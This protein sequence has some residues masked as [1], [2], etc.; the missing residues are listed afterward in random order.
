MTKEDEENFGSSMK[1]WFCNNTFVEGGVKVI[2]Y[3][4][5]TGEYRGAGHRDCNINVSVNYIISIVFYNLKNHDTHLIM[6]ELGNF[7]FEINFIPDGLEKYTS[8][9]IDNELV[10]IDSFQFFFFIF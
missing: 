10:F 1:C 3:C 5:G 7:D 8:F 4:H 9:S 6:R 2:D